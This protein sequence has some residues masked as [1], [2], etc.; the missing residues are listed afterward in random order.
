MLGSGP[1]PFFLQLEYLEILYNANPIQNVGFYIIPV[2]HPV[3]VITRRNPVKHEINEPQ[4]PRERRTGGRLEA[5]RGE[6]GSNCDLG[7]QHNNMRNLYPI[8][9]K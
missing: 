7:V 2:R 5:Q 4:D 3:Q 6:G 8:C 9:F 1:G